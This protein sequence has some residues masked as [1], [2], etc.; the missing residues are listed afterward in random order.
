MPVTRDLSENKRLTIL[1]WLE[2]PIIDEPA[3]MEADDEIRL[4]PALTSEIGQLTD[5]QVQ[6]RAA[7]RLKN[8][9]VISCPEV[10]DLFQF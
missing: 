6:L 2:D 4:A 5:Q 9:S 1:K 3:E 8:G 10:T 7:T